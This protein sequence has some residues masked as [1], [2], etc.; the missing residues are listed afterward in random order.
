M[1]TLQDLYRTLDQTRRS[2]DLTL[3]AGSAGAPNLD[4]FLATLPGLSITLHRPQVRLTN[5]R[6]PATLVV[7]GGMTGAWALPGLPAVTLN[8]Q[9]ATVTYRQAG[10]AS[11]VTADLTVTATIAI[12]RDTS[13]LSGSLGPGSILSFAEQHGG[14]ANISLADAAALLA[15]GSAAGWIPADVPVFGTLGLSSLGL[16]VG[17]AP[18]SSTL[19]FT[20]DAPNHGSWEILAG[21]HVLRQ[22]GVTLIASYQTGPGRTPRRSFSGNVHAV[23]DLGQQVGVTIWFGPGHVWVIELDATGGLPA[24]ATIAAVAGAQDEV[25]AGLAAIGLGDVTLQAVR[26]GFDRATGALAFIEMRGSI[27]VAGTAFGVWLQLP[28]FSFGGMLAPYTPISLTALLEHTLGGAGGLPDIEVTMLALEADPQSGN[29]SLLADLEDGQLTAASYGLAGVELELGKDSTGMTG[30]ISA[31]ITLAGTLILVSG[32]YGPGWTVSGQLDQLPVAALIGEVLAEAGLPNPLANLQLS[33]VSA[34]WNLTTG[35]YSFGG[36]LDIGVQLGPLALTSTVTLAVDSAVDAQSGQRTTTGVLTGSLTLGG[37]VFTLRYA[38]VPGQQ[39][40]TG[41]WN[42]QGQASF[43]DLA[44]AFGLAVPGSDISLPDLSLTSM[45]FMLD[46]S[47]TGE[48]A[49][50]LTAATSIGDAFFAVDRPQPGQPWAFAFGAAIAGATKLSQVLAPIGLDGTA[51]DFI[52]LSGACFLVASAPFPAL[53]IPGFGQLAGQP[54]PVSQGLTA[55]VLVDLGGTPD[56]PDVSV[57]KTVLS[58]QPTVLLGEVTL[59]TSLAAVAVTAQLAGSLKITGAGTASVTLSNV[60][61]ILK[62]EPLALTLAGSVEFPLGSTTLLATGLLTVAANEVTGA[63]NVQGENGQVL[64]IPMGF[65]GVHLTDLGVEIGV[66]YEPPAL[67]MGVLGRFV[68]GPGDAAPQGPVASRPLSAMPPPD[69]FVLI[70]GLEGEVPD[71]LL[72]SMYLQELSFSAAVEAFTNQQAALPAVLNDISASDLMIYWCDAPAGLQQPDGTWAYPGFGFNATLDLY[73]LHAYAELKINSTSGISGNACIDPL[74]IPGVIDLAGDG[75]GTPTA[76][77]GQVTVRPGG[78]QIQVSTTTSP[79]LDISWQLTLFSTLTQSVNAQL[80]SSGFTFAADASAFGFSS[81]LACAFQTSGHLSMTFTLSVTVDADLGS[82][83]G[84]QLGHVHLADV[85]VSCGLAADAAPALRITIDASFE[86]DGASYRMPQ[87]SVTTP[88]SSL[89]DIPDAIAGQIENEGATI[90]AGFIADA[91]SYL[92]Q[93]RQGLI[94]AGTE[95]GSVLRTGYGLTEDQAAA[96]MKTAGYGITDIGTALISGWGSSAGDVANA[97]E[98]AGYSVSDAGTFLKNAFSLGPDQLHGVLQ[99]AGYAV[100]QIN[101]FFHDL[102]GD[103]A[104][105]ASNL[106]PTKW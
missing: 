57:L 83:G 97:L 26:I 30:R 39:V 79:Y 60:S 3:T 38:F 10:T 75:P 24:I 37:Q 78:A 41:T 15:P 54:V 31:E 101:G 20:L 47:K 17:Y 46:W 70:L 36:Q 6:Q 71:P 13:T 48:Q 33:N 76:Y 12:G 94:T 50:E 25:R 44:S 87:I 5:G 42:A 4:D 100:D 51:L 34:T 53:Q 99:T 89:A 22:I 82:L 67:V 85:A 32:S 43:A 29:Y 56:R 80:T 16:S 64:P 102:G 69:E 21:Q 66:T 96:A 98:S 49:F 9:D 106:D 58:G 77:T 95:I 73:G 23:L 91:A 1:T 65:Q 2:G 27:L 61:L 104:S 11:P 103:F 59:S 81:A 63:L 52:T 90:F 68:I 92:D 8:M 45:A 105:L 55:A 18:G 19:Q 74:G 28:S 14:H 88:F 62:P 40:L 72:L 86:F 7:S 84:V 93:V 35:A